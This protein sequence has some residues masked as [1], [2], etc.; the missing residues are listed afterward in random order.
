MQSCMYVYVYVCVC[1][2]VYVYGYGYMCAPPLLK[3]ALLLLQVHFTEL[4]VTKAELVE[5][6]M[7]V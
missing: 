3:A 4:K 2:Y 6:Y 5:E 7:E 1:V